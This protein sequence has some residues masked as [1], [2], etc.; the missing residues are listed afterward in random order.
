MVTARLK[1]YDRAQVL[2]AHALDVDADPDLNVKHAALLQR[3][4]GA[5]HPPGDAS[6]EAAKAVLHRGEVELEG[7]PFTE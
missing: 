2:I 1:Q 4:K 3:L 6:M 7:L 5:E